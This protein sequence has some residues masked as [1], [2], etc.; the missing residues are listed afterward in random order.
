MIKVLVVDDEILVRAGIR[1]LIDWEGEGFVY[2]GD[3][4]N[5][6]EALEIIQRH[7][8]DIVL[9][10]I[11]MPQMDGLELIRRC[12]EEFP[13]VRFIV[14]SSHKDY[15]YVRQAMKMG[16]DDYLLKTSMK[17]DEL[18]ELLKEAAKKIVVHKTSEGISKGVF[19][20][21]SQNLEQ[22]LYQL[23][24]G[25]CKEQT[26]QTVQAAMGWEDPHSLRCMMLMQVH[27][28]PESK[29]GVD[30]L[31]V[32]ELHTEKWKQGSWVKL[33]ERELVLLSG[34]HP[35]KQEELRIL[36]KL[37]SDVISAAQRFVNKS[38]S[39]GISGS[40]APIGKLREV[41][42]EAKEAVLRSYYEG[43]GQ[44][45][46]YSRKGFTRDVG[47]IMNQTVEE[48]LKYF[49]D[50]G[51]ISRVSQL[52]HDALQKMFDIRSHPEANVHVFLDILHQLKGSIRKESPEWLA[53]CCQDW[54]KH[55]L[56]F[57]TLDGA[58]IWF[59]DILAWYGQR[60]TADK[61][62]S[63][64]TEIKQVMEYVAEHFH[65]PLSL[66]TV[67]E[68]IGISEGYLSAVFKKETGM[69]FVEYV[70]ELRIQK[71]AA[72]MRTTDLPHYVIAEKVGYENT[73][74]FSR[75]FK[76]MTGMS[77]TLY[78]EQHRK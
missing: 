51:D 64:R 74:Y 49:L 14:L 41:Y 54:Y 22:S 77:P 46:T 8:P 37:G 3:C 2:A 44:V 57:E 78:R 43:T 47:I 15:E 20:T 5:G 61:Q 32:V 36:Q 58:A 17:P 68:Y 65:E 29:L 28:S 21:H 11:E 31:D 76:K 72:Y 4:P 13:K 48:K 69:N 39:I 12:R 24:H 26:I 42:V 19:R 53:E 63:Y 7:Q 16:V 27:G 56:E 52:I 70:T 10:D 62:A 34:K 67:S 23:I 71:A 66:G 38:V 33:S 30:L 18:L 9:T 25:E 35:T 50:C 45:Y 73:N 40:A 55:V 59:N 60:L 6:L 1:S 75:I